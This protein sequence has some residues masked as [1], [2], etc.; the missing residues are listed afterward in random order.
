MTCPIYILA[1]LTEEEL[2]CLHKIL[3]QS[4][5]L[6]RA[7]ALKEAFFKVLSMKDPTSVKVFL[8]RWLQFVEESGIEEFKRILKMFKT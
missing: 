1:S 6:Q 7:Y 2:V 3:K 4:P 8:S 5:Q